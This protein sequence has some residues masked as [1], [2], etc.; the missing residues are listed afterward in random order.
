MQRLKPNPYRP[1]P[2][3]QTGFYVAQIGFQLTM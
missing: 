2:R 1:F 3:S